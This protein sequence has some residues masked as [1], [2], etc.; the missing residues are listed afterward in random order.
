[1]TSD[2]L[3]PALPLPVLCRSSGGR[4]VCRSL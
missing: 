3:L 2:L 1:M 4:L